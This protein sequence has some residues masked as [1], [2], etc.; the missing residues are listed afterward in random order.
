MNK[1]WGKIIKD[2]ITSGIKI[3]FGI[4]YWFVF[5]LF[6]LIGWATKGIGL[7]IVFAILFGGG[8][9]LITRMVKNMIR[10]AQHTHANR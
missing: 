1:D 2:S 4:S 7:G 10:K 6:I 3:S 9:M 5:G 8:Y